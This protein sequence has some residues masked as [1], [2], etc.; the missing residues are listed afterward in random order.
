ML[1]VDIPDAFFYGALLVLI[2]S[3][4]GLTT[5]LIRTLLHVSEVLVSHTDWLDRIQRRIDEK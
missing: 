1:A 4:I 5:W 2:P 3:A